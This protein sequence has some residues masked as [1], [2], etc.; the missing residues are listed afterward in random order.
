[1]DPDGAIDVA[2]PSAAAVR[3][4][5]PTAGSEPARDV[6]PAVAVAAEPPDHSGLEARVAALE[7]EVAS[8]RAQLDELLA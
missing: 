3:V 5:T 6:P 4:T 2:A 1:M 8:L 7:G